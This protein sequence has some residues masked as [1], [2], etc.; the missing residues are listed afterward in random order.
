M[1]FLND[2]ELDALFSEDEMVISTSSSSPPPPPQPLTK[3]SVF[4]SLPPEMRNTVYTD[5][6]TTYYASNPNIKINAYGELILPPILHASRDMHTETQGYYYNA[7]VH[8]A[9]HSGKDFRIEAQIASYDFAPLHSRLHSLSRQFGVPVENLLARTR[10]SYGGDF[11]FANIMA[12]ITQHLADPVAC[13]R[14]GQHE[15]R[16]PTLP[17]FGA[18]GLFGGSLSLLEAVRTYRQAIKEG[19]RLLLKWTVAARE[20]L[21]NAEYLGFGEGCPSGVKHNE[22][23][24]LVFRVL[25]IW[26]HTMR[27]NMSD[28]ALGQARAGQ[29]R[30][31]RQRHSDMANVV[32]AFWLGCGHV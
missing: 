31:L 20:F 12:W 1:S 11:N 23:S 7:H 17:S 16:M 15:D 28:R 13:P 2:S 26:H 3:F 29:L 27:V 19:G 21:A 25:A 8:A 22:L 10:V 24:E 32:Y 6:F 18:M 14:L 4:A 5:Y 30:E 9:L